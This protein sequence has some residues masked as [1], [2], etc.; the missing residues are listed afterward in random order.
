[1]T[2]APLVVSI[3][4]L[5]SPQAAGHPFIY[6]KSLKEAADSLGWTHWAAVQ[7]IDPKLPMIHALPDH[8]TP[9]LVGLHYERI[10]ALPPLQRPLAMQRAVFAT[11][12]SIVRYIQAVV[13]PEQQRTQRPV[14]YFVDFFTISHLLP[15]TLAMRQAPLRNA[16]LWLVYRMDVAHRRT[17]PLYRWVTRYL[18]RILPAH[19]LVML[20]DSDLLRVSISH[21]LGASVQTLPIPHAVGWNVDAL[22]T[23]QPIE[24][25]RTRGLQIGWLP[26]I[27]RI[28][29]GVETIRN[30]TKRVGEGA[31]AFA[32]AA[33]ASA[34]LQAMPGGCEVIAVPNELSQQ[35]YGS[36]L[37]SC[38]FVILPYVSHEYAERT[39]GPFVEAVV[40]G[41]PPLVTD[42]T[43]MA[44]E[45]RRF[46]LAE[47]IVDFDQADVFA[48][49]H[50]RLAS[51]EVHRK[52]TQMQVAYGKYHSVANFAAEIRHIYSEMKAEG[53]R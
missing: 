6:N 35:A 31:A 18:R 2:E 46:D 17:A 32:L 10:A 24:Q 29:K 37:S 22:W 19:A 48:Q 51:K 38:D 8:W 3:G 15:L 13:A 41:K 9:C 45:L 26:G 20:T 43:W 52:L 34:D 28:D 33:S 53:K 49:I 1:M 7:T 40:A 11:A 5:V 14:I 39:S 12:D 44:H 27:A 50:A 16:S 4:M 36:W 42:S 21:M 23:P 47:L 25:A 30:L